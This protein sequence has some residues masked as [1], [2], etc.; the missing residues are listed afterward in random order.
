MRNHKPPP[1]AR[2]SSAGQPVLDQGIA[3][4]GDLV[5]QLLGLRLLPI[6]VRLLI[7]SSQLATEFGLDWWRDES[8]GKAKRA[9]TETKSR[10]NGRPAQ[11]P[12]RAAGDEAR[13]RPARAR[14]R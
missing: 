12:R 8:A 6:K 2:Q 14:R 11:A 1:R 4:T 10:S 3:I 13:R 5:I 7:S 9:E